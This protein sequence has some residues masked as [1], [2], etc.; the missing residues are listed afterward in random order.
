M[1]DEA[2]FNKAAELYELAHIERS[3]ADSFDAKDLQFTTQDHLAA[4]PAEAWETLTFT[5]QK[6]VRVL[7]LHDNSFPIWKA[8]AEENRPPKLEKTEATA[9]ILWRRSDLITHYRVLSEAEIVI[10]DLAIKGETFAVMCE[11]LLDFFSEQETPTRAI[12]FLQLWIQEE[13]LAGFEY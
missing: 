9:W 8:L 10:L 1:R 2:P 3:F 11:K 4:L 6:S 13:M 7:W 12:S 5:F